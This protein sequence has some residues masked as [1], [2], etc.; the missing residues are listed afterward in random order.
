MTVSNHVQDTHELACTNYNAGD[1]A[2]IGYDMAEHDYHND[3]A[4]RRND[5]TSIEWE[6][7]P[8]GLKCRDKMHKHKPNWGVFEQA[9]MEYGDNRGTLKHDVHVPAQYL[10]NH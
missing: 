8:K 10:F 9:S 6:T 5:R 3:S 1:H 2:C 7:E 4:D